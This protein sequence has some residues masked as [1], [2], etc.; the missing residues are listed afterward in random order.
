MHKHVL[1]AVIRG[2]EAEAFDDVEPF[3]AP[4]AATTAENSATWRENRDMMTII[5]EWL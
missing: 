1:S 2:D 5:I 3:T 4:R